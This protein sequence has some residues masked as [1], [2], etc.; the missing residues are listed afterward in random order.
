MSEPTLKD[1][2]PAGTP[3]PRRSWRRF[4]FLAACVAIFAIAAPICFYMWASSEATQE[5]VRQRIHGRKGGAPGAAR[6]AGTERKIAFAQAKEQSGDLPAVPR[7]PRTR[8][9]RPPRAD[10]PRARR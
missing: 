5:L 2:L 9:G 6:G 1:S 8:G 7:R 4:L 10:R 3:P